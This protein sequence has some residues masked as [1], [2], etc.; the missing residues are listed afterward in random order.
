MLHVLV[1]AHLLNIQPTPGWWERM[2]TLFF[3]YVLGISEEERLV[4]RATR[5]FMENR[6]GVVDRAVRAAGQAVVAADIVGQ[7][8]HAVDVQ[9]PAMSILLGQ[10]PAFADPR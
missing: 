5:Q 1:G 7:P 9:D 4:T 10:L 8:L 6:S 2:K 3:M